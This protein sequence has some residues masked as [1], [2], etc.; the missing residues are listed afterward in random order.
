[1]KVGIVVPFSW[2]YWGGVVDHAESQAHALAALGHDVRILIGNDPPGRLTRLLHPRPGRHGPLPEYVIPVG[3]TVIV[4]ANASLSNLVLTPQAMVRM[5]RAFAREQFDVVHVHEPLAPIL[6]QYALAA[7]PCPLVTTSHAAGGRW[8]PWGKRFWPVLIP[9]IDHRIAVS[10]EA[11]RAAEPWLGGP[12]EILPNGVDLPAAPDPGG[13]ENRV[14]FIGRHEPRKGLQVLLRAWPRIA[15]RTGARLRVIGADPLSVAFLLRR[16]EV[17]DPSIELLGVVPTQTLLEE[18]GAAKVLAAPAIG[19]ETFGMV[20]TQAFA[21]ATPVVASDIAG[22]REVAGPETG[23]LV[24]PGDEDALV[25]GICTLLEDEARRR[26]LGARAREVAEDR[27]SW[28]R[29][30]GRLVEIYSSLIG[31]PVAQRAAAR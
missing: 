27:Y 2:S 22:Y 29:L 13:R 25:L 23:I 3:R 1:M 8:H 16:L 15:A 24:P 7:A 28:G 20:L 21:T 10:E 9:R 4:P 14:L 30:A 19:G 17:S 18:L 31:V 12:F 11:R 5:K 26:A 6:S